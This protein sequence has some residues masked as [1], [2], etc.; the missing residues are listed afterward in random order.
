MEKIALYI[1]IT[2]AF[3]AYINTTAETIIA[4]ENHSIFPIPVNMVGVVDENAPEFGTKA[5]F[6]MCYN[7]YETYE[8]RIKFCS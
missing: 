7:D 8:K 6:T 2:I 3:I 4:S 5:W 1:I